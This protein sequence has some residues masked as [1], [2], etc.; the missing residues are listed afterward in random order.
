MSEPTERRLN[1]SRKPK[2]HFDDQIAQLKPSEPSIARNAP[3]KPTS[4][5]T[6]KPTLVAK[7]TAKA[8]AKLT[9]ELTKPTATKPSTTKP[10][11]LSAIQSIC[12]RIEGLEIDGKARKKA[13]VEEIARLTTLNLRSIM[14]E[15]KPIKEV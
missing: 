6:K 2:I 13:K 15:V 1:R 9:A 12:S 7:S 11:D 3:A 5:S 4:K 8:G 10:T 14:E